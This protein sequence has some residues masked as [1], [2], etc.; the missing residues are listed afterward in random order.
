M[1]AAPK[2]SSLEESEFLSGLSRDDLERRIVLL[3]EEQES[4]NAFGKGHEDQCAHCGAD[5]Y[6]G[7]GHCHQWSE[8]L[9][10]LTR[11]FINLEDD[12]QKTREYLE[13]SK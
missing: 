8:E 5:K 10:P 1:E 12:L 11:S 6:S 2:P 9:I 4:V 7:C 13:K 3:Q